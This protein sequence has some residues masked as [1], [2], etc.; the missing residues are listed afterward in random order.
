MKRNAVIK[1]L[2]AEAKR[3]G[4]EFEEIALS[5]HDA[6]RVG[7]TT[8]TLGRY[9]EIDDVTVKKFFDQY[10]QELGKGWWR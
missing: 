10:A 9:R 1:K 7:S 4:L 5:R 3:R 6:Y 8:R 2:K